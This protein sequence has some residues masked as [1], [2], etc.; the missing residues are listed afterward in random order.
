MMMKPQ[1]D[2][3]GFRLS[4]LNQKQYRHLWL[5]AFWPLFGVFFKVLEDAFAGP[6][7]PVHCALDD[8]I[9][10]CEWFLLP[11][12]FWFVFLAGSLAFAA[13]CAPNTFRRTMAFIMLTYIVTGIVYFVYPTCQQLRP[14]EFPRDNILTRLTEWIYTI[15]TNTNV[16]PSIHVI[17]SFAA[18]FAL[19]DS[20]VFRKRPVWQIVCWLITILICAST[21]FLKQHSAL[22]IVFALPLCLVGYLTCFVHWKEISKKR[23]N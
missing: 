1:I 21:V 20:G 2:V 19:L 6:Y 16:C 15:D 22:D 9:P 4:K 23:T 17:G 7:H 12:L 11:Y 3:K 8:A 18:L 5:L 14:L 13:I 10:F